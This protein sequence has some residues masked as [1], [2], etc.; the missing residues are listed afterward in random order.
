[1]TSACLSQTS[2]THVHHSTLEKSKAFPL[3]KMCRLSRVYILAKGALG[4]DKRVLLQ[5]ENPHARLPRTRTKSP[6][7]IFFSLA[8]RFVPRRVS[9]DICDWRFRPFNTSLCLHTYYVWGTTGSF[10]SYVG[11][12]LKRNRRTKPDGAAHVEVVQVASAAVNAPNASVA[13]IEV[14]RRQRPPISICSIFL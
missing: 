13:A 7:T 3:L 2:K 1:M 8:C 6:L 14:A 10:S 12:R 5:K 9:R 4:C 11:R